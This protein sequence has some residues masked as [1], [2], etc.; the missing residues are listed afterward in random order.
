[1]ENWLSIFGIVGIFDRDTI[2]PDP[3]QSFKTP[4]P[5]SKAVHIINCHVSRG[6]AT[7]ADNFKIVVQDGPALYVGGT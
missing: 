5:D 7:V 4:C 2:K 1:M 6:N 3:D